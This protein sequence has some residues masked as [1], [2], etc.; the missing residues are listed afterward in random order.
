MNNRYLDKKFMSKAPLIVVS[1]AVAAIMIAGFSSKRVKHEYCWTREFASGEKHVAARMTPD[2]VTRLLRNVRDP[3]IDINVVDLGL[4]YK[5][6][7]DDEVVTITMTLTTPSCSYGPELI[8]EV[9][10]EVFKENVRSLRLIITF[11]P[12]W[13]SSRIA[14]EAF[15]KLFT[16]ARS[17]K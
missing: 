11:D 16:Q 5:V 9:K 2:E 1:C 17:A 12:P 14:P 3:E 10:K 6:S 7:V 13:T 8:T 4:I 15:R